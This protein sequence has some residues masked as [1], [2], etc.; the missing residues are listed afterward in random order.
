MAFSQGA[1]VRQQLHFTVYIAAM[2]LFLFILLLFLSFLFFAILFFTTLFFPSPSFSFLFSF[3][4]FTFLSFSF[5]FPFPFFVFPFLFPLFLL[6]SILFL[7]RLFLSLS[8]PLL[9]S[10][11]FPLPSSFSFISSGPRSQS[12]RRFPIG[13]RCVPLLGA[14]NMPILYYTIPPPRDLLFVSVLCI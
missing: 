13:Y 12:G 2:A 11:L 14:A 5:L 9:S 3:L 1:L 10:S 6:F 4:P 8:F 7:I